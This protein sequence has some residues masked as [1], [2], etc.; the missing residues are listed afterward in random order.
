CQLWGCE[1]L[2]RLAGPVNWCP[3]GPGRGRLEQ[4]VAD[5]D[6][7]SAKLVIARRPVAH[8]FEDWRSATY[9]TRTSL[10]VEY[11]TQSSI[12]HHD[13]GALRRG[14][15][16]VTSAG[17]IRAGVLLRSA[18]LQQLRCLVVQ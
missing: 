13:V 15:R 6:V 16:R 8:T 5:A 4:A 14:T 3:V 7:L 18:E 9:L 2:S 12:P 1:T 11:E 10:E 17:R